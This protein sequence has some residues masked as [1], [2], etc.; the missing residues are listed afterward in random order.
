M[1]A[2]QSRRQTTPWAMPWADK[3][4][5][6]IRTWKEAGEDNV[7]IVAAGVAFYG[8]LA[9]VPLIAATVLTY[10]LVADPR[11]V[12]GTMERLTQVMPAQAADV[13]GEQLMSAVQTSGGK[14][15]FG[16]LL[17]LALALF[18]ARNGAG[19]VITALNIAYEEKEKRGVVILNL[20][21]LAITAA[22][23]LVA[24]VAVGAM[25]ALSALD[26]WLSHSPAL[27]LV[28]QVV[29]YLF[30]ALA[31]AA[32]AAT[33]YRFGPSRTKPRW[34]WI[35]PGSILA[36]VGWVVLTL[37]FGFYVSSFGNYN[38]TYGSLGAIVVLLTWLYL[39]AYILIF[40]AEL[41]SEFEHQTAGDTTAGANK[42]AGR[43][44]AWA[45]D[46]VAGEGAPAAPVRGKPA[47]PAAAGGMVASA[48]ATGVAI[49]LKRR[50]SALVLLVATA[51]LARK[52]DEPAG[53][54]H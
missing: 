52:P 39:S 53:R 54:A 48:V 16:L 40:G 20:T 3:K 13:V 1:M 26:E 47:H 17:A 9:I 12:L 33:L 8:F 23:V 2:Q 45:A 5:V 46:H 7:G 44:G 10:G 32:A 41:N 18:G 42:P 49:L 31:G 37:G 38:A 21:A 24:I 19:A 27:A 34:T 35:T 28:G 14:K 4:A 43:R 25:T 51:R 50:W 29:S 11:T 36:S 30:L 22:A 6:L 15:G